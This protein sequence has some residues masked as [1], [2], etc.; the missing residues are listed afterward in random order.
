MSFKAQSIAA[1][2]LGLHFSPFH[3]LVDKKKKEIEVYFF[4]RIC[5]QLMHILSEKNKRVSHLLIPAVL[6]CALRGNKN[7][8]L[9]S[10]S[11]L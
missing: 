11:M 3:V 1:S 9:S 10:A 2:G 6:H 4:F 7:K 8:L 5:Y